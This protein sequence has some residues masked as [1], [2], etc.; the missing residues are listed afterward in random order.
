[1]PKEIKYYVETLRQLKGI[2]GIENYLGEVETINAAI[3]ALI[4]KYKIKQA[5][6]A[7]KQ[8][9][10]NYYFNEKLLEA[11]IFTLCLNLLEGVNDDKRG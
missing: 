11:D 5:I 9:R 7:I 3:D 2:S 6:E 10:D 8:I 1:M 4:Y